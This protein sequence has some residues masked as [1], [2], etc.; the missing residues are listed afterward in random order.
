MLSAFGPFLWDFTLKRFA[1]AFLIDAFDKSE[2]RRWQGLMSFFLRL[3][4]LWI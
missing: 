4:P 2:L 3:N 1:D